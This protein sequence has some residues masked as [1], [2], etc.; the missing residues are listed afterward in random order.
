MDGVMCG[1]MSHTGFCFLDEE[2][3]AS[4][5]ARF[6]FSLSESLPESLSESE[7]LPESLPESLSVWE[8]L[9]ESLSQSLSLI[10]FMA[11]TDGVMETE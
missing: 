4:A 10:C 8:S 11:W 7:S 3:A 1:D 6:T 5:I 9:P 2:A